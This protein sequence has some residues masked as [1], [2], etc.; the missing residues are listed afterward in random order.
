MIGLFERVCG[1][2]R[3][4]IMIMIYTT[5]INM[6]F[7]IL[8]VFIVKKKEKSQIIRIDRIIFIFTIYRLLIE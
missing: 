5:M 4:K 2:R 6:H 1:I 3:Y 7:L 8:F